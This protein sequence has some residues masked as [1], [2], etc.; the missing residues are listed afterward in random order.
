[1]KSED[2]PPYKMYTLDSERL[3][4]IEALSEEPPQSPTIHMPTSLRRLIISDDEDEDVRI[5]M[6][7]TEELLR[8]SKKKKKKKESTAL[9][10]QKELVQSSCESDQGIGSMPSSI[11]SVSGHGNPLPEEK[12]DDD[13]SVSTVE[14]RSRKKGLATKRSELL[15]DKP[16]IPNIHVGS[17]LKAMLEENKFSTG[18]TKK[19]LT[20]K[21]GKWDAI[22]KN[23]NENQKTTEKRT[24]KEVKSKVFGDLGG[25]SSPRAKTPKSGSNAK[26][27]SNNSGRS[28]SRT[29]LAST[30]RTESYQSESHRDKAN[31]TVRRYANSNG[32]DTH[33]KSSIPS[34]NTTAP[35]LSARKSKDRRYPPNNCNSSNNVV[36]GSTTNGVVGHSSSSNQPDLVKSST[37][38]G[39]NEKYSG[40][41]EDEV[42]A[43][44]RQVDELRRR[45]N[46]ANKGFDVMTLMYNRALSKV[47]H[48]N[49][50]R[51]KD[52]ET[53]ITSLEKKLNLKD[54]EIDDLKKE[55]S[56]LKD[57]LESELSKY[58][59]DKTGVTEDFNRRLSQ[60]KTQHGT[61]LEKVERNYRDDLEEL[62]ANHSRVLLETQ[63]AAE[64]KLHNILEE[65]EN[66]WKTKILQELSEKEE[67]LRQLVND[68]ASKE[69]EWESQKF[70]FSQRINDLIYQIESQRTTSSPDK[71]NNANTSNIN[72]TTPPLF[73]STPTVP[74]TPKLKSKNPEDSVI[75]NLNAEVESLKA[76]VDMRTVDVHQ[77][78]KD[79]VALEERLAEFDK[80][81]C[82]HA[83]TLAQLED[84]RAQIESKSVLERK[85]SEENR[86]LQT[87]V[88]RELVEKKRLSMENEELLWKIHKENSTSGDMY[89]NQTMSF[90]EGVSPRN[91]LF[92]YDEDEA[93]KL[94]YSFT[95]GVSTSPFKTKSGLSRSMSLKERKMGVVMNG[96]R[97]S[98]HRTSSI[99]IMSTSLPPTRHGKS[100]FVREVIDKGDSVSWKIEYED[101]NVH[102][103]LPFSPGPKR[104]S[105]SGL[106]GSLA[107]SCPP[108]V[109]LTRR[110]V[111][112][113][114]SS[115]LY[116][117]PLSE[118]S[119]E[120]SVGGIG[121]NAGGGPLSVDIVKNSDVIINA[122][123]ISSSS[124]IEIDEKS[125]LPEEE[126]TL[127]P[128]CMA[129]SLPSYDLHML[130]SNQSSSSCKESGGESLMTLEEETTTTTT[131]TTTTRESGTT[132]DEDTKTE[133]TMTD[134]LSAVSWSDDFEE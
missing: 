76:V 78:R 90:I 95:E 16:I 28:S 23:I 41:L 21:M 114:S 66:R 31:D 69:I 122:D 91:V 57:E 109:S 128:E 85:L 42:D 89:N 62:K 27:N 105:T 9:L 92:D 51:N 80:M 133:R 1:M 74:S 18:G 37:R 3:R 82:E 36:V 52:L 32:L 106:G 55:E 35:K 19:R 121:S 86:Y 61:L 131:T 125:P 118:S 29:S 111:G 26:S 8:S 56:K 7:R 60:I 83:K 102:P 24:Y 44:N 49:S 14:T 112:L 96:A 129:T 20:K 134:S 65:T 12:E 59:N 64:A 124:E 48:P 46:D 99:D 17:K 132:E 30:G 104:R 25:S 94:S 47:H 84:L 81:K 70:K 71:T 88:E 67:S 127:R 97:H 58:K 15:Q 10:Q 38:L 63:E 107:L 73:T 130:F 4:A 116:N 87:S 126:K 22:M 119:S 6:E 103:I 50:S 54:Q 45:L 117:E 100:A 115:F 2:D 79:N 43:K 72:N 98:A 120:S 93:A 101:K 68:S 113:S 13:D 5:L 39:E 33:K 40:R 75:F 77:L 123:D 53:Q 11:I 110:K 34:S 108:S